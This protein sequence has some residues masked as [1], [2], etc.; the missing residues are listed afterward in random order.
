MLNLSLRQLRYFDAL[1]HHR[2]FGR[3]AEACAISQPAMSEQIKE[4]ESAFGAALFERNAR[5]VR[6]TSLGEALSARVRAI[7]AAIDD[8]E[9]LAASHPP[10]RRLR[11]GVI[12][13]VAPYLLPALMRDVAATY[14]GLELRIRETI[15]ASLMEELGAGR[16]D[17][18]VLALPVAGRG[19][20][21]MTLFSEEFLV[22]RAEAE[23]GEPAPDL[24]TLAQERLLLLEE[25]HCLR[26][27]ALAFCGLDA[28]RAREILEASTLSTLVQ[29]VG[30]GLGVTLIPEMAVAVEARSAPVAVTRCVAPRPSR[31]LGMVWRKSHPLGAQLREIGE[32]VRRAGAACLAG[33]RREPEGQQELAPPRARRKPPSAGAA[34]LP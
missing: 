11:L 21:A 20:E 22:V 27:Q 4:L 5:G 8:L 24:A 6:A 32:A 16:L 25:G 15:T 29:M 14:P 34:R 19:F 3:A 13:T 18:A 7:L 28:S 12:P 23:A 26:D 30:A 2:H 17:A 31:T 10:R 9:A 1:A 33:A